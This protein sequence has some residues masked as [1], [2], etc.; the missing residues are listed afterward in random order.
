M[1]ADGFED[2][3]AL[4]YYW[5]LIFDYNHLF[6]GDDGC[7]IEELVEVDAACEGEGEG[8]LSFQVAYI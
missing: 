7:I 1:R 5:E 2:S 4:C 6:G 8:F 3:S